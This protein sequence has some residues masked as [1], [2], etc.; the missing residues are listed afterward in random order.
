MQGSFLVAL[1]VA[2]SVSALVASGEVG[3]ALSDALLVLGELGADDVCSGFHL[4]AKLLLGEQDRLLDGKPCIAF[5]AAGAANLGDAC[6]A[7]GRHLVAQ[8]PGFVFQGVGLGGDG[9]EL[10]RRDRGTAGSPEAA[11]ATGNLASANV[12]FHQRLFQVDISA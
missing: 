2:L 6:K 1:I 7:Q 3:A 12:A 10:P 5:A 9:D 4:D 11:Y 8:R